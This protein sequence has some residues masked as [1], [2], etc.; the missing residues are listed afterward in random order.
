MEGK[1]DRWGE[2][3]GAGKEAARRGEFDLAQN[4]FLEALH[5]AEGEP[6]FERRLE[7]SLHSLALFYYSFE[8]YAEAEPYWQRGLSCIEGRCG[9]ASREAGTYLYNMAEMI[10]RPQGKHSVADELRRRAESICG[11]GFFNIASS[12][13]A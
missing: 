10:Y 4:S 9:A 3:V 2:L 1:L 12:P 13:P 11:P 8:R 5:L 6:E 7:D